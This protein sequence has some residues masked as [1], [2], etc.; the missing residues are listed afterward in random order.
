MQGWAPRGP[1]SHG[2]PPRHKGL[3][4]PRSTAYEPPKNGLLGDWVPPQEA[5]WG[6]P[7]GVPPPEP[8][9]SDTSVGAVA[10]TTMQADGG[11]DEEADCHHGAEEGRAADLGVGARKAPGGGTPGGGPSR[12]SWWRDH[13]EAVLRGLRRPCF[14]G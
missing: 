11:N 9:G 6:L 8:S 7:P 10:V 14:G 13:Q 3:L 4:S 5:L 2:S 12:A 1:R